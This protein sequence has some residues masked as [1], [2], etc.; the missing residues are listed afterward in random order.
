M[1]EETHG[2]YAMKYVVLNAVNGTTLGIRL[3]ELELVE[4]GEQGEEQG[5]VGVI[6]VNQVVTRP[7]NVG[8]NVELVA[9]LTILHTFVGITQVMGNPKGLGELPRL[10]RSLTL[11][12]CLLNQ[13]LKR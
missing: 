9:N 3:R 13:L 4:Q 1:A 5:L 10:L 6:L 2:S 8:G 12:C 7:Q 11:Q